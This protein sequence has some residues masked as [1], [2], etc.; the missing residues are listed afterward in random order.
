LALDPV[1]PAGTSMGDS[2]QDTPF[3]SSVD[4]LGKG[5]KHNQGGEMVARGWTLQRRQAAAEN[6]R[7]VKAAL[8]PTQRAEAVRKANATRAARGWHPKSL[9]NL[10]PGG[11][12]ARKH[13][14]QHQRAGKSGWTP[15]R[16]AAQATRLARVRLKGP[17]LAATVRRV[18]RLQRN[19][20]YRSRRAR[21]A[22][23]PERRRVQ[24]AR[25]AVQHRDPAFHANATENLEFWRNQKVAA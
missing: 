18:R 1:L 22:W 12:R 10:R 14:L 8:T 11:R 15:Q 13:R 9:A 20:L 17:E 2:P 23:T 3:L 16:R 5:T 24:A 7:R 21:E 4:A 19:R 6:L 25:L